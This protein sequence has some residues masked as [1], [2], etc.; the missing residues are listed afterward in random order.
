MAFNT[1]K[2]ID[3]CENTR[4]VF[5]NTNA[6]I[7]KHVYPTHFRTKACHESISRLGIFGRTELQKGRIYACNDKHPPITRHIHKARETTRLK[8][9][10][11]KKCVH[12]PLV[13][14]V[15]SHDPVSPWIV[16]L[17]LLSL[18]RHFILVS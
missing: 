14:V 1:K 18:I 3:W 8:N 17:V 16:A 7:E 4:T 9:I 5:K 11:R 12:P 10:P 6:S 15:A 2:R 13:S